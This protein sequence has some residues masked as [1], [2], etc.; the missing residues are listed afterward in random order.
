MIYPASPFAA[1]LQCY[2]E[3]AQRREAIGLSET[4]NGHI[5]DIGDYISPHIVLAFPDFPPLPHHVIFS[6][7][8]LTSTIFHCKSIAMLPVTFNQVVGA[9]LC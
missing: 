9:L 7:P 8:P 4:C 2:I 3:E 5:F 1:L 6:M